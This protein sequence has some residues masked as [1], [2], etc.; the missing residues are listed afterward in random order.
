MDKKRRDFIKKAYTA[1]ILIAMGALIPSYVEG[2]SCPHPN[3]AG[4]C[5]PGH[6]RR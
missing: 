2:G 1:P 4:H 5:P 3:P 6:N